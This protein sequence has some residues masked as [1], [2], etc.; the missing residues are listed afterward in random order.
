MEF[1]VQ[2][3]ELALNNNMDCWFFNRGGEIEYEEYL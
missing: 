3:E 2:E 1:S